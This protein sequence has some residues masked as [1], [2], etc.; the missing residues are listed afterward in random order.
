M[1]QGDAQSRPGDRK[2]QK[3]RDRARKRARKKRTVRRWSAKGGQWAQK[4]ARIMNILKSRKAL[5]ADPP[6]SRW[7]T[8]FRSIYA[9][10]NVNRPKRSSLYPPFLPRHRRCYETTPLVR[11]SSD[12]PVPFPSLFFPALARSRRSP[13]PRQGPRSINARFLR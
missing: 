7:G 5:S 1:S 3:E 4:R 2:K 8:V 10:S 6:G 9:T 12:P 13:P 11:L